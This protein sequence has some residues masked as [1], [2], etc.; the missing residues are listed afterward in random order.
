MFDFFKNR[1]PSYAYDEI[2]KKL[3]FQLETLERA[4]ENIYEILKTIVGIVHAKSG[5]LFL[6]HPDSKIFVLKKWVGEKPLMVSVSGDYEFTHYL[7]TTQSVLFK[8]EVL[9]ETRYVDIRAAGIHYF[10]QLACASVVPLIVKNE[11]IGLLN[12]GRTN[13]QQTNLEEDREILLLLGHWLSHHLYN[14]ILYE[15]VGRQN[16]KLA[17]M[18]EL[19]NQLIANVTHELR[20]PLNGILGLTNL[21]LEEAD[22][23]LLEDQKRHLTMIQSAGESLLDIV[24]NMLSLIKIEAGKENNGVRKLGLSSI[25]N[26]IGALFEGI[27]ASNAN[28]F[29]SRVPQDFI[30]YGDEDQIRTVFM[31]LIGNAVKF[32]KNGQ[33][34]VHA[35]KSGDMV[36]LCVK[37]SGIGI[38][39]EAQ[40]R[41]FEEFH[42]GDGSITRSYGGTGLGLTIAKKIIEKHGGRIWVDSILGKGSEFYF[43]LPMKPVGI[44]ATE[45]S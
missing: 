36:R 1:K 41:V 42:Q 4:S 12:I 29:Q 32:T 34:E 33:I 18:T 43:T 10:T 19:K 28:C 45:L 7:K 24:N 39:D 15:E 40:L 35:E 13:Q 14:A 31:N 5:S 38:A 20:T 26:E 44:E 16:K 37:D 3:M 8:N 23:P 9:Q 21:I 22:G 25:I 6:F 11:W 17:E 27:L 30:V 2:F